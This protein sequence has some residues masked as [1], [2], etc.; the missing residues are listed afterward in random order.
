M[1]VCTTTCVLSCSLDIYALKAY[2]TTSK[3]MKRELREEY[4][5][6]GRTFSTI[7]RIV[8]ETDNSFATRPGPTYRGGRYAI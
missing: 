6:L 2:R 1:S 3:L 7:Y 4:K 5:L 8:L